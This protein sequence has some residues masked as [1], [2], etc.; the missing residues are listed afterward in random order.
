MPDKDMM[1][2]LYI[3]APALVFWLVL[4]LLMRP[5]FRSAGL[6]PTA[7]ATALLAIVAGGVLVLL[8]GGLGDGMVAGSVAAGGG[9]QMIG[10]GPYIPGRNSYFRDLPFVALAV[11]GAAMLTKGLTQS[12]VVG[13]GTRLRRIMAGF[14]TYAF[15]AGA[16]VS[17][18]LALGPVTAMPGRYIDGPEA[19]FWQENAGML[20]GALLLAGAGLVLLALSLTLIRKTVRA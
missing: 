12:E 2:S 15:H 1:L 11:A 20:A 16:G 14:G 3:T 19:F 8:G 10:D 5:A 18:L 6:P 17:A 13:T 7:A 4:P 9:D